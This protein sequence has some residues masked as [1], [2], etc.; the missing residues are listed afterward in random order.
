[1]IDG[2]GEIPQTINDRVIVNGE[3]FWF[4]FYVF[5]A[6]TEVAENVTVHVLMNDILIYEENIEIMASF[7]LKE[8]VMTKYP[9]IY[10]AKV[11]DF[12]KIELEVDP[13]NVIKE[14]DEDNNYKYIDKGI[15]VIKSDIEIT[16]I[17]FL[18]DGDEV[19]G[20]ELKAGD[21]IDIRALLA[22]KGSEPVNVTALFRAGGTLLGEV[23]TSAK[24]VPEPPQNTLQY[25]DYTSYV[26][27]TT[28]TTQIT[29]EISSEFPRE[30]DYANNLLGSDIEVISTKSDG[31]GGDNQMLMWLIIIIIIIIVVVALVA[32]LLLRKKKREKMAEC[33]E[34]GALIPVNASACPKCGAEFSD[35]VECGECGALMKVTDTK[36]PVCGAVFAKEGE[37][38]EGEEEAEAGEKPKP[39]V[40]ARE[41]AKKPTPPAKKPEAAKAKPAPPAAKAAPAPPAAAI[42]APPSAPAPPAAAKPVTG[43]EEEE[44]KAE[45]YRCGAIVPLSASMCP[46]CGAEFE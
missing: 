43:G 23:K 29:V 21:V 26:V 15:E 8:I 1:M 9:A 38:E 14:S 36:C 6:G 32:F 16:A 11:S 18:R 27:D 35:E 42:P 30:E 2:P 46:E 25:V 33:S 10:D 41:E 4:E 37:E 45:C 44:E 7:E 17:K 20:N 22:N 40:P 19:L 5:N 24:I 3:S 28:D 34:C 39:G 12:Q 31:D 13:E